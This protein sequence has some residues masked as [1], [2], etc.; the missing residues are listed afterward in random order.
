MAHDAKKRTELRRRYVQDR[1]PLNA[2]A[3]LSK[4]SYATARSWKSAAEKRGDDWDRARMAND[5]GDGGVSELTRIVLEEFIPLFK[6]TIK[7]IRSDKL[8]GIEKAEAI[9]RISDAYAKTVKASGAVDP[10]I[11]KLGWAME[12]MRQLAQ[13]TAEHFPK[14][15]GAL[16]DVLEPFGEYLASE[17]G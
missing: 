17:H 12:V 11:A 16:L 6:S 3:L 8:D 7:A 4:V 9:S 5:V 15:Q 2:A 1:Q 10:S 13:F 14:H